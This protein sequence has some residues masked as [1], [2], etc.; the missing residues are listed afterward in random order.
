[1]HWQVYSEISQQNWNGY[2]VTHIRMCTS[3]YAPAPNRRGIK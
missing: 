3:Y 2:L 1:M